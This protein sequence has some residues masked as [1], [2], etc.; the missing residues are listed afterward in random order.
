MTASREV[1]EEL[2]ELSRDE[3][4]GLVRTVLE[5]NADPILVLDDEGTVLF[6]N[7]AA[8]R[9]LGR[10]RLAGRPFGFPLSGDEPAELDVVVDGRPRVFEMRLNETQL[11]GQHARVA[12][13]RDVTVRKHTEDSLRGFVSTASHEFQTPLAAIN[14]VLEILIEDGVESERELTEN[15]QLVQRQAERLR[16]LADDLL[17]LSRLDAGRRDPSPQVLRLSDALRYAIRMS[18]DTEEFELY[19]PDGVMVVADPDHLHQIIC[20]YVSNAVKYGAAPYA[21]TCDLEDGGA[22]VRVCDRGDGVPPSFQPRLFERFSRLRSGGS[23][24][25]GTGLGLAI[26][27]ELAQLNGGHAWY[28]DHDGGGAAFCVSFPLA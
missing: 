17:M 20:N 5:H 13:L 8:H 21:V 18:A 11:R 12:T 25:G 24:P 19:V 14:A 27:S 22:V 7:P 4:Q 10:D 9:A 28:E 3:L 23:G 26:V 1:G 6:A 15:L 2:E 16:R